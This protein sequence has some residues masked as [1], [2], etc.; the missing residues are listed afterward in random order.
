MFFQSPI[1][2]VSN[3][4]VFSIKGQRV[5]IFSFMG[6]MDSVSIATQ[7]WRGSAEIVTGNS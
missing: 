1:G 2:R 4:Q 7:L 3:E 5:E 6:Q